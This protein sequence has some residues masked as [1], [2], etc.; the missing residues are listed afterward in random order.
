MVK[1]QSAGAIV[2]RITEDGR[3][4]YL[5]LQAAIGKPWGFPKG[6]LDEGETDE[7]AAR[8]EIAE[9]AGLEHVILDDDFR[10]VVHYNYRRGRVLVKKEVIYFLARIN[11]LEVHLSWEHVAFLWVSLHEA[12]D[13]VH[14]ENARELLR[15]AHRHLEKHY[16]PMN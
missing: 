10:H 11:S 12:L 3:V 2:Y 4:V 15:K 14:Y 6:K 1:E 8:R 7:A 9:E 5:L 13:L 16:G